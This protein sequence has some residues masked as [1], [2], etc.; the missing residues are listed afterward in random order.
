MEEELI[1]TYLRKP[2]ANETGEFLTA[3][4][5]I[6]LIGLSV[7]TNLQPRHVAIVMKRLGF[8]QRRTRVAR[9]WN[10]VILTG[11]EI[12]NNQRQNAHQSSRDD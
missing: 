8:E 5:I 12:K 11:D 2:Y 3:S 4:R 10:V 9:G 1:L 6:E 7:R